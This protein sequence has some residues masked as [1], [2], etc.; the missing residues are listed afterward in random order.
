MDW[1]EGGGKSGDAERREEKGGLGKGGKQ[2]DYSFGGVNYKTGRFR[3]LRLSSSV[4]SLCEICK[5][6]IEELILFK[7]I[8]CPPLIK[9]SV[10]PRGNL[11][12]I[13]S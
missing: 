1:G 5:S 10:S 12:L 4:I 7:S 8:D 13:K 6:V 11:S 2:T 3:F 9:Y